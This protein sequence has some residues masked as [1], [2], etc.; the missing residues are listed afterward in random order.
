ILT[1]LRLH[2]EFG[3]RVVLHHVSDGWKVADAI[4]AAKVPCS[5]IVVD[6]PGGKIEAKDASLGT[7]AALE[8]A[9]VA[10]AFHTDDPI[11]DSRLLFRSAALAVRAGM[12]R[13]K[14]LDALTLA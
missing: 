12:S 2:E 3:F 9:G 11:T 10:V 1:V 13:E 7:G 6:S 14:A 5:V 4:A 8:K